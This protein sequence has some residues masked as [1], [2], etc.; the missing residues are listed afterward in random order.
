VSGVGIERETQLVGA[1]EAVASA[2][3]RMREPD[4]ERVAR[5][6][7]AVHAIATTTREHGEASV[8]TALAA[9]AASMIAPVDPSAV[10]WNAFRMF[11]VEEAETA[12]TKWNAALLS[13]E[14]GAALSRLV[15]RSFCEAVLE[16]HD[17]VTD[18]GP[19]GAGVFATA[20]DWETARDVPLPPGSVDREVSDPELGRPDIVIETPALLVVLENKLDAGWHDGEQT[21]AAKYRRFG[22]KYRRERKLGL[23]LLT[24]RDDFEMGADGTDYVRVLYR[25]LAR[26][27]RRNLGRVLEVDSSPSTMLSLWPAL[28]TVAAIEQDL[29]GFDIQGAVANAAS[30]SWR[31]MSG[32]NEIVDHLHEERP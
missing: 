4:P 8:R 1:I 3:R 2:V 12:W 27:L 10:T 18:G 16:Q 32:L 17:A 5:L 14:N 31:A 7:R 15:W 11:E 19:R 23:V 21:Q 26:A 9:I 22:V 28:M 20:Q 6:E 25:D 13:P 30:R 29:L 24:K